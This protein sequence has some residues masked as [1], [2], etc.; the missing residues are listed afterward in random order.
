MSLVSIIIPYYKKKLYIGEAV[1]SAINQTF[2]NIEIII[3]YDDPVKNDLPFLKKL[4]IKDK[5]IKLIINE[6]NEG[7]GNSRNIGVKKATGE[8]IAFLDADD[9]WSNNKIEIQL[10]FMKKN[11]SNI[12][13]TS[14]KILSKK[15]KYNLR[16]ARDFNKLSDLLKSC[17]IGLSTVMIKKNMLNNECKFPKMNTKEDFVLWL[18]ILKNGSKIQ[19]LDSALTTWRQTENSLSSSIYQKMKDGFDVYYKHMNFNLF[20]AFFYLICL[21]INYIKKS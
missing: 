15:L 12:S 8:Y 1:N 10:S 19:G 11:H 4:S 5:R 7:A 20:K 21:S 14:Y 9:L 16:K 18:K 13:H 6:K 3:I 17:D 2:K